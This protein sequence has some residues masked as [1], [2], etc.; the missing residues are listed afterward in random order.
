MKTK[1][2][3]LLFLMLSFCLSIPVL[4]LRAEEPEI[5][6][7]LPSITFLKKEKRSI[8]TST[9]TAPL[10]S[11][12]QSLRNARNSTGWNDDFEFDGTIKDENVGHPA[13]IGNATMPIVISIIVLY[14]M[15]RLRN[16]ST[17]KRRNNL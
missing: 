10:S 12:I 16:T 3:I 5:S 14:L 9:T 15:F 11:P 1:L 8:A 17:T 7:E 4:S 6:G 2:Q 13:P